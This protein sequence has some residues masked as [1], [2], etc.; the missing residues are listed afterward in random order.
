[1]RPL[2]GGLFIVPL[3]P[4]FWIVQCVITQISHFRALLDSWQAYD[5]VRFGAAFK[6]NAS[7]EG[8]A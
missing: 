8:C 4:I 2:A 6:E 3:P 7:H 5:A 1:M